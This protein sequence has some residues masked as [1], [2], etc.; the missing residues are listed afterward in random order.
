MAGLSAGGAMATVL[1]AA[2]PDLFAA[3]AVHS[4]LA[5]KSA[6]SVPSAFVAMARG[7]RKVGDLA[8]PVPSLVIH[9]SDDRTVAPANG[10]Q[11]LA[12][13]MAAMRAPLR[14]ARPTTSSRGRVGGGHAYEHHN[15]RMAAEVCT[16]G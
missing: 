16:S 3:V 1:A 7:G 13:T 11:V 5:Y 15:G 6:H 10:D 8:R 14:P 9:G 2:Y 12:Q 4:G